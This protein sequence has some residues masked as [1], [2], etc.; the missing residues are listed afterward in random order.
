MLT[1]LVVLVTLAQANRQASKQAGRQLMLVYKSEKERWNRQKGLEIRQSW[2]V[3]ARFRSAKHRLDCA[4]RRGSV[5][6]VP[7]AIIR[8]R[9]RWRAKA[10]GVSP[11][12]EEAEEPLLLLLVLLECSR[13]R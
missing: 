8:A 7:K 12:S 13:T 4:R 6:V 1:V 11:A 3:F 5:L 9:R 2:F 10:E